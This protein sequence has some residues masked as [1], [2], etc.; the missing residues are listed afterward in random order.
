MG[1]ALGL[2]GRFRRDSIAGLAL[3][4]IALIFAD[5]ANISGI[6][7]PYTVG[8]CAVVL[9]I[10]LGSRFEA[11]WLY[12]QPLA[13]CMFG[14]YLMHPLMLSLTGHITGQ[15]S[16]ATVIIAYGSSAAVVWFVRRQMPIS[17][18]ILG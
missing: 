15:H 2:G 1:V 17:R 16:M 13:D 8:A 4:V 9:A 12:V 7:L 3:L 6:S 11:P 18:K 5:L 14:V 10:W